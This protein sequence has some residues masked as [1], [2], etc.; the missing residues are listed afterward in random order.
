[1]WPCLS[2]VVDKLVHFLLPF[3]CLSI[4]V[5]CTEADHTC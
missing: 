1:M 2:C 3:V 4:E 5:Y